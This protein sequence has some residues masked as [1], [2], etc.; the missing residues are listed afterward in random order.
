[1]VEFVHSRFFHTIMTQKEALTILKMGHNVFLTGQAGSGKT[2][3]LNQ[4][5]EYLKRWSVGVAVTASTGIAATHLNGTTIHSW[6]GIGIRD[7]MTD[8]EIQALA[9]KKKLAGRIRVAKTLVID[10]ISMLHSY[11]L[12]LIERVLRITRGNFAPFGGI[13]VVFSGDFFQLPPVTREGDAADHFA[14]KSDAWRVADLR[15]CYLESQHRHTDVA[16]LSV[17]N[18]IRGNAVS[19]KTVAVLE[20]RY[21]E[22]ILPERMTW[23]Y[24]HNADV[25]AINNRELVKLSGK[26]N[27]YIMQDS[28][29][30]KLVAELKRNCL[31][32]ETITLK[33]ETLVMFVKNNFERGYVNGTL[34][35]VLRFDEYG[36]PVVRTR[37]GRTIAVLPE[38]WRFEENGR[39]V[40]EISQIPLRL[41]WSITVH[42]SQGMS[43]D[44]AEVDLSKSFEPGMGYVALSRVR[45]LGGLRL[46]GLNDTA[47]TVNNEASTFDKELAMRSDEEAATVRALSLQEIEKRQQAFLAVAK[48]RDSSVVHR[49]RTCAL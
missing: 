42:K 12:D 46:M 16:Y 17:L 19:P 24:T 21:G 25:D 18:D 4:Y 47:F 22:R 28:G 26:P 40:A 33:P 23:L 14:F 5:V 39:T 29:S 49:G 44:A 8:K 15:V 45:T 1:M 27:T 13:Q 6:A 37:G 31:A 34:G 7:E 36:T 30:K 3:L 11:R 48:P 43:L 32:Q 10:E 2:Y 9:K 38:S 41:A 20:C 35:T